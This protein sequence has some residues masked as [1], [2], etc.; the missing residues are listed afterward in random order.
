MSTAPRPHTSPST[1]SPPNGSWRQPSALTGTTSVWPIS[2]SVG[3]VGSRA[4]DAGDEVRPARAR[5]VASRG[6]ARCPRGTSRST[7]A[8]RVSLPDSAVPSLTHALRIRCCSSSV[9]SAVGSSMRGTVGG[10]DDR[11]S[12]AG[13]LTDGRPWLAPCPGTSSS[14]AR[15]S[16]P[17]AARCRASSSSTRPCRAFMTENPDAHG[18]RRRRRHVRPS[19]R[20]GRASRRSRRRSSPAS[21]CRRRPGAIGRGDAFVLQIAD[22]ADAMVL[23]N[24][25][26]QEFHGEYAWLFDEGRLIG[27]KPVPARRLGVRA[28]Q[29]GPRADQP[30]GARGPRRRATA[31]RPAKKLASRPVGGGLGAD[32][33]AEGPAADEAQGGRS[34]RSRGRRGGEAVGACRSEA[35]GRTRSTRCSR[36]SSSS[37]TIP[38]ARPSRRPSSRSPRTAPT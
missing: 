16:P 17:K 35:Q 8:L 18:H 7:S 5:L 1:S 3:A 32:A 25:S 24:D 21:S 29:P 36:S 27:G 14:T 28:P 10:A 31:E 12:A 4:L 13:W 19:H 2:S 26:F 20:R 33:R 30:P 23:S 34:C 11:P 15:T 37:P 6:R 22:K 38:S 9:T